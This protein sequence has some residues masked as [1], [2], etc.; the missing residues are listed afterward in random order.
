MLLLALAATMA[1]P[2]DGKTMAVD[3][4]HALAIYGVA[5]ETDGAIYLQAHAGD[6][7]RDGVPDDAVIR[8]VCERGKPIE[9]AMNFEHEVKS[10]RDVATGQASGKRQHGSIKIVKEW[11][12]ATP[13]LSRLNPTYDVK[14]IKSARVTGN[15]P[16][17]PVALS[18]VD[19]FCD[20]AQQAAKGAVKTRSNIQNN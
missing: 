20:A 1:A 10:P 7:D 15:P 18:N 16:W 2:D 14:T 11:G 5:A 9:S 12:A 3:D 8:L 13:Q 6:L 17:V 4:W 19:G